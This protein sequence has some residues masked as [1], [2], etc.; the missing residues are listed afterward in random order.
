M[1]QYRANNERKDMKRQDKKLKQSGKMGQVQ[2]KR[3]NIKKH[4][5]EEDGI[6]QKSGGEIMTQSRTQS[7]N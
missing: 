7:R 4:E 2:K 5:G 3:K 1:V 6:Q